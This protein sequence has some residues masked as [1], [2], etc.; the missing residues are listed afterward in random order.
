[1][2]GASRCQLLLHLVVVDLKRAKLELVLVSLELVCLDLLLEL[3]DLGLT[4]A[5]HLAEANHLTLVLLKLTSGVL[6]VLHKRLGLLLVSVHQLFCLGQFERQV[7]LLAHESV[8]CRLEHV[9]FELHLRV[10]LL[11]IL[12]FVTEEV[13]RVLDLLGPQVIFFE[14]APLDSKFTLC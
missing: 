9:H 7:L 13:E 2:I 4:L 1:M 6:E 3:L 14:L 12:N 11:G 10:L 8:I 5:V